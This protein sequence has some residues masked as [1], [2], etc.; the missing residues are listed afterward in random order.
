MYAIKIP[1]WDG[2][3][4]HEADMRAGARHFKDASWRIYLILRRLIQSGFM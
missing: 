1:S 2:V 3:E 4:L